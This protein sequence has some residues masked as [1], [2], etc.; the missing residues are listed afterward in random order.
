MN[1]IR[2]IV[3]IFM[4]IFFISACDKKPVDQ[5]NPLAVTYSQDGGAYQKP[6][7]ETLPPEYTMT[8]K[9]LDIEESNVLT[10]YHN[11]QTKLR[12]VNK[13]F[14]TYHTELDLYE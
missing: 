4:M 1:K 2:Y 8:I 13:L 10:L 14:I 7:L 12:W 9:A 5:N 3:V 11:D 6:F